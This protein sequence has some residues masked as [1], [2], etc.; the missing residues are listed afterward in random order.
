MKVR[1]TSGPKQGTIEH[2]P[3]HICQP[4][5]AAGIC[6]HV[7][8]KTQNGV[9]DYVQRLREEASPVAPPP[10]VE[11]GVQSAAI[12][13]FK[14]DTVIKKVGT[15]TIYFSECPPDAPLTIQK[16]WADL[17]GLDLNANSRAVDK[18]KQEQQ[19]RE[20]REKVQKYQVAFGK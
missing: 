16:Q 10:V 9:P 3:P 13:A 18:A 20:E 8:Y 12:S 11:W 6:E 19:E 1:F 4:L 5:I 15:E 17:K 7:P 14:Q 2:L